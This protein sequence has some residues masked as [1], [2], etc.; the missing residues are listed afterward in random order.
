[1]FTGLARLGIL[2]VVLLLVCSTTVLP[3][4][5]EEIWSELGKLSGEQRYRFLLSKA[6]EEREVAWYTSLAADQ[7]EPLREDFEKRYPGIQMKEWRGRGESVVNR[8]LTEAKAGRF[9]VD[10]VSG[11][12]E[13]FPVV[14][15][16][17]LVGRYS[18]PERKF[19]SD[20]HKDREGYWTSLVDVV[21]VMAYNTRLVPKSDVPKRFEDFLDP[22]WMSNFAVDTNPDRAVMVWLKMWGNEKTEKF[23]QGLLQN[24]AAVR[25]GHNLIVQLLCAG[26]FKAAI[27][28]YAFRVLSVKQQGCPAEMVFSNPTPGAVTPVYVA[29]RSPHPYAAALL[30][31]Y[32]LS[33]SGQRILVDKGL[34]HSGRHGVKPKYPELDLERRGVR[35]LLLTPEDVEALGKNYFQLREKYLLIR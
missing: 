23:L 2:V 8:L 1:M 21:V 25:S 28:V 5:P 11:S 29:K 30:I 13:N 26:E 27:E 34:L 17:N 3:K 12:N 6:K 32:L 7:L 20:T 35:A 31:D 19:Y 18:S 22:K 33:D 4:E 15:K 14:M 9:S 16:A 10:V 24:D